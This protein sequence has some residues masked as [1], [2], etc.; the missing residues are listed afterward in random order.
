MDDLQKQLPNIDLRTYLG[1]I[2]HTMPAELN[3]KE[4]DSLA[5]LN[6]YMTADNLFLL[7]DYV[8]LANLEKNAITQAEAPLSGTWLLRIVLLGTQSQSR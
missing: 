1:K 8:Y 3:I 5:K 6:S 4:T 2:F 7:K